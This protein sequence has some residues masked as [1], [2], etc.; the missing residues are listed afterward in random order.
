MHKPLRRRQTFFGRGRVRDDR[1]QLRGHGGVEQA[2]L[3]QVRDY[4]GWV[5]SVIVVA[6]TC[7]DLC[8]GAALLGSVRAVLDALQAVGDALRALL[9]LGR[10]CRNCLLRSGRRRRR[11]RRRGRGYR[12]GAANA[13][14]TA[15]VEAPLP[16][17]KALTAPLRSLSDTGLLLALGFP[18][19]PTHNLFRKRAG[20]LGSFVLLLNGTLLCGRFSIIVGNLLC[21]CRCH[22]GNCMSISQWL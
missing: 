1:L 11:N 2:A 3:L 4:I 12:L 14:A 19:V 15:I 17:A 16:G 18:A 22:F 6:A 5:K 8:Q 13:R 21:I 7:D 10:V 9:S 20:V